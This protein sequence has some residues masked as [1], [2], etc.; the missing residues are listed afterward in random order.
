MN[1]SQF[2][3]LA[4][5]YTELWRSHQAL[6]AYGRFKRTIVAGEWS[7]IDDAGRA[8][9]D[10][11]TH[12][13]NLAVLDL[14]CG[15]GQATARLLSAVG[16]TKVRY[17]GVDCCADALARHHLDEGLCLHVE[18]HNDD[19][20][21]FLARQPPAADLVVWLHSAYAMTAESAAILRP[22]LSRAQLGIMLMNSSR[23]VLHNIKAA[24]QRPALGAEHMHDLLGRQGVFVEAQTHRYEIA[25]NVAGCA[26]LCVDETALGAAPV[27]VPQFDVSLRLRGDHSVRA[28]SMW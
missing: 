9:R 8:I 7:A 22:W 4:R 26:Y 14:G 6:E 19:M 15:D 16:A 13:S 2:S 18:L 24:G 10:D 21:D 28:S 23:S 17:V 27:E 11:M 1:E 20:N 25:L 3:A 12:L 5:Q